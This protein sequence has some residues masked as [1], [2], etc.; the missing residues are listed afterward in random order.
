VNSTLAAAIAAIRAGCR[1]AHLEAGLRSFDREMPEEL[2][3]I[4]V[5]H[6]SDLLFVTEPSGRANLEREGVPQARIR[7]VGNTMIDTLMR[8][9]SLRRQSVMSPIAGLE[10]DKP[11]ILVTVHRPALV[12]HVEGLARLLAIL[13]YA[14]KKATVLFPVHPRT[15]R[16]MTEHGLAEA[17]FSVERL[18]ITEPL[19]YLEFLGLMERA[20][21]VMTDSGGI[22]EETTVLGT[23]CLTL[24]E[25]TERPVTCTEGTNRIV[26]TDPLLVA[27]AVDEVWDNP[28]QGRV[29]EGW[30]GT[31]AERV[32]SALL[33]TEIGAQAVA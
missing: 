23:P 12:D 22:Q 29:P 2:N 24:R 31:A 19:G 4:A 33:A 9:R 26:G 1:L 15:R 3:R 8:W 11:L 21:L 7:F 5:D 13:S 27:K 14:A 28:P 16:R 17:F 6:L 20:R 32:V 18:V 25:N 10:P 30:D